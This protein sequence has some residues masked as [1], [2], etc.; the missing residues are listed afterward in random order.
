MLREPQP[1][2]QFVGLATDVI[3]LHA[4]DACKETDILAD[5]QIF[6]KREFLRHIADVLLDFFVLGAD[7]VASHGA[8]AAGGL[9]QSCEHVHGGGLTCA[10]GSEEAENLAPLHAETDVIDGMER[11]EGLH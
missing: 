11:A 5:G 9:V 4:V 10:V 3:V 1:L 6:V 7:V 8:R 2:Q